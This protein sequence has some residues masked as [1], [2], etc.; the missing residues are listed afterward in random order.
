MVDSAVNWI[1]DNWAP[2][3]IKIA[4]AIA[5]YIIG[6]IV[7]SIVG[8]QLTKALKKANRMSELMIGFTVNIVEK[9]LLLIV[10]MIALK[11]LGI[12][13]TPLIAGLGVTGFI[14]GFAFQETLGNFAAGFMI[15]LNQPFTIGHVVDAGGILG[16]VVDM[17]MMAVTLHT[18]DNKKIT[19]PNSKIWGSAIT[20]FSALETRRV[21]M[22]VGVSYGADLNKTKEVVAK[23][24]DSH[25]LILKDPAPI[26]EVVEMADSS[27]NFVVRPWVKN[28]DYWTVLFACQKGIKEA[29]DEAGIEIPFPQMDVHF[30]AGLFTKENAS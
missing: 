3:A 28:A 6:K 16:K 29:L 10:I 24:L 4:V 8:A 7:I 25:E 21:D 22:T 17:N 19:V 1:R 30:D 14:I 5:I 13:V 18:G 12:D 20:N 11:Q 23:V 2:F 27:V 26:I 9:V 15:A